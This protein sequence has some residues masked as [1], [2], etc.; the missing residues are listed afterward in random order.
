MSRFGDELNAFIKGTTQKLRGD[1]F[2]HVVLESERSIKFG[3]ELT[4]APGQ[5]V[6]KGALLRSWITEF[7]TPDLAEISTPMEYA[8]PVEEG[9]GS[10]GQPVVYGAA[11]NGRSQVGGSH[12]V[13]LTIAGFP[14]IVDA[15]VKRVNS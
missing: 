1:V 2:P 12:S 6:D 3:S 15:C 13:K 8:E 9:L 14:R 4:N 7:H 11:G 5:P 10:R